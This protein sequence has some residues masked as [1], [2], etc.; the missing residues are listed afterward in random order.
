MIFHLDDIIL[1][2][3]IGLLIGFVI[4][5]TLWD[6]TVRGIK[7]QAIEKGFAKWIP[8]KDGICEFTW[9]EDKK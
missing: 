2:T 7:R 6:S 4:G 3:V 9:N 5:I 1:F 8:D